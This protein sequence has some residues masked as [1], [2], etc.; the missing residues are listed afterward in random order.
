M[1]AVEKQYNLCCLLAVR[2]YKY[3]KHYYQLQ[4]WVI[5]TGKQYLLVLTG[6][7]IDT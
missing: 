5:D 4:A 1:Q 6:D 7:Q 3:K 2:M